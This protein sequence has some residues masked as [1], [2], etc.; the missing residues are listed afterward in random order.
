MHTMRTAAICLAMLVA[1]GCSSERA[2]APVR[3]PPLPPVPKAQ[4]VPLDPALREQAARQLRGLVTDREPAVRAHAIEGLRDGLG[5]AA[6]AEIVPALSDPSARC[7]YAAAM[8][9]GEL[10]L[11]T[12]REPLLALVD[13][14]DPSVRIAARFALHRLGDTTR[15]HD[16]E[17]TIRDPSPNV[18]GDT[19]MVLGLLGEP[20]ALPLLQAMHAD[21][22]PAIRL[23]A[24]EARWRLH[25]EPAAGILIA[26]TLSAHPDDQ[27][28]SILGL[29]APRD[30]RVM[31][32]VRSKLTSEYVEVGLATARAMGMLG[33]DE[34]YGL[35]TKH[36]DSDQRVRRLLAGLA[37]GAI[38]RPDAQRFLAPRLSDPDPHVRVA[39]ATAILQLRAKEPA[40]GQR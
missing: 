10:R 37:L 35:A 30:Q 29:A 12:A 14:A 19:A 26:G 4:V 20:S 13:D 21:P 38:G 40:T 31:E 22:D 17:A 11:T 5:V 32:H 7:R 1:A 34:G 16:L 24:A 2:T 28:N 18:R 25:D 6:E 33:S 39:V 9:A 36:I 23:Q 3:P 8:A 27:I 15:T